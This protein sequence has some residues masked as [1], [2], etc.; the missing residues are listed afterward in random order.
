MKERLDGWKAIADYCG[1]SQRAVQRWAEN[2]EFPVRRAPGGGVVYAWP[3][4]VDA[5]FAKQ[6]G[7]DEGE[8]PPESIRPAPELPVQAVEPVR[9]LP[10]PAPS[11]PSAPA[12]T[13]PRVTLA[14]GVGH[15]LFL[16]AGVIIGVAGYHLY[17][18][19]PA[20]PV[21]LEPCHAVRWPTDSLPASGGRRWVP[22]Q[23]LASPCGWVAPATDA[24]WLLIT[25]PAQS[26]TPPRLS[27]AG[28][29]PL[30]LPEYVPSAGNLAIEFAAN[31][32]SEERRAIL[33]FGSQTITITQAA[34]PPGCA[35]IPGPGFEHDGW[36][37]RIT[38]K[39]YS[40]TVPWMKAVEDELGRP[41]FPV[42]WDDF[43]ALVKG[44]PEQG[45]AFAEAVG[46]YRH[47]WQESRDTAFCFGYFL[48]GETEPRF[49]AYHLGRK[50]LSFAAYDEVNDNQFDLGRYQ[51]TFQILYR[52]PVR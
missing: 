20:S 30:D 51:L 4:E 41:A 27:L 47:S 34:G 49:L 37:Y 21:A 50:A 8:C 2:R 5:W 6:V 52:E 11:P 9:P 13:A 22:V 24:T 16:V 14:I 32:T 1:R 40:S 33:R 36:R 42:S 38:A 44:R 7:T 48:S 3:S 12:P 28:I 17:T 39:R 31:N 23:R 18:R 45:A 19:P 43:V 10:G 46:V 29:N 35:S 15:A 25:P 26:A